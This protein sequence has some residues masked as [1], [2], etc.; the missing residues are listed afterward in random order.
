MKLIKQIPNL[1]TLL[2]LVLGCIGILYAF[3]ERYFLLTKSQHGVYQTYEI[4]NRLFTSGICIMIAACID[5]LDGFVARML[6]AQSAIGKQL[7]SLA[8]LVTFGVLPAIIYYQLLERSFFLE[9][10]SLYTSKIFLLPALLIA[11]TACWRL[12]KFNISE[13]QNENFLG[14]PSPA[15]ALFVSALPFIAL[16]NDFGLGNLLLNKWI[17][18]SLVILFSVLMVSNIKMFSLKMKSFSFKGNEMRYAFLLL[19]IALIALLHFTG[20]ALC[21]LFYILLSVIN[22]FLPKKD[23][24]II[25]K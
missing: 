12:A 21:I 10:G 7:D 24:G 5:F 16:S 25:P 4:S 14:L 3:D 18:Y 22:N 1:L 23:E 20:L 17:V 11:V 2:N 9:T 6:N 13:K 19:S 15:S 8:D